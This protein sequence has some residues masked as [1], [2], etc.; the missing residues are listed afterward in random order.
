MKQTTAS[1]FFDILYYKIG[2]I[3]ICI[4]ENFKLNLK[5]IAAGVYKLRIPEANFPSCY[6][7][8]IYS[9]IRT[10]LKGTR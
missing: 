8:Q 9:H 6:L 10:A 7:C 1:V 5:I 4:F 3:I 2:N